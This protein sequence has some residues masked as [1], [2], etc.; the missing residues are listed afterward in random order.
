MVT[1]VGD[2]L[3]FGMYSFV[4][5]AYSQGQSYLRLLLLIVE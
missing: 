1:F 4:L 2:G 3:P 5:C